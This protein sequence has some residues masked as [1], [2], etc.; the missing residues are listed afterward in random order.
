MVPLQ[1]GG[2]QRGA[3]EPLHQGPAVAARRPSQGRTEGKEK[4]QGLRDGANGFFFLI[5]VLFFK[6][7]TIIIK[8]KKLIKAEQ[9]VM[10][11]SFINP[12]LSYCACCAA[13]SIEPTVYKKS[14]EKH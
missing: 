13:K 4:P 5:P 7:K 9:Y 11:I 14:S 6:T 8:Y 1:R 3:E 10:F 12:V 2:V